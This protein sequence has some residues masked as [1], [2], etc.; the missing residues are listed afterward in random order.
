M[1]DLNHAAG[2]SRCPVHYPGNLKIWRS[3]DPSLR[4]RVRFPCPRGFGE[5][6]ELVLARSW[7]GPKRAARSSFAAPGDSVP[8]TFIER[9]LDDNLAWKRQASMN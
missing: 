8:R 1:P 5:S 2:R 4:P 9:S 7:N 3:R 6:W